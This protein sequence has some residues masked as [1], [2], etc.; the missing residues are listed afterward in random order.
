MILLEQATSGE[1]AKLLVAA[2]PF[3]ID[4]T[5]VWPVA[6]LLVAA[7][8]KVARAVKFSARSEGSQIALPGKDMTSGIRIIWA[9][10]QSRT[11]RN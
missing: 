9:T 8:G 5:G 4:A 6:P 7:V 10:R 2:L 1:D 3:V 11:R